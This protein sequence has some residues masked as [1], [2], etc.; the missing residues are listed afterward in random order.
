[1]SQTD[2]QLLAKFVAD[3][4]ESAFRQLVERNLDHSHSV[5]FRIARNAETARD[6]AQQVFTKLATN[7]SS[8]PKHIPFQSWLHT[9]T[10]SLAIDMVRSEQARSNREV[11]YADS[12]TMNTSE[13][14][15]WKQ[16]EPVLDEVIEQL[17]PADQQIIVLRFYR[18]LSHAE[19][20]IETGVTANAARVRLQRALE[21]MRILL[22]RKGIT[23]TAALLASALPGHA[24]TPA[25]AGMSMAIAQSALA[26][27]ATTATSTTTLSLL[28]MTKLQT[29]AI[30]TGIGLISLSIWQGSRIADL[31][32]TN[33][34]LIHQMDQNARMELKAE[35]PAA[36]TGDTLHDVKL[37]NKLV[38]AS[39]NLKSSLH[40]MLLLLKV[41]S[42]RPV[43]HPMPPGPGMRRRAES[44]DYR[45]AVRSIASALI[46]EV[47]SA[48]E[49]WDSVAAE[50]PSVQRDRLLAEIAKQDMPKL[51]HRGG[52]WQE[53]I[54]DRLTEI[55]K[56]SLGLRQ[57]QQVMALADALDHGHGGGIEAFA[58]SRANPD[59]IANLEAK[60]ASPET[61]EVERE[62]MKQWVEL[63]KLRGIDV[64]TW[65]EQLNAL[66][67]VVSRAPA[68][69][70]EYDE[71][72]RTLARMASH[73]DADVAISWIDAI[74]DEAIRRNAALEYVDNERRR[75]AR[76]AAAAAGQD[77]YSHPILKM[78]EE[79]SGTGR[80]M[81]EFLRE[82][83]EIEAMNHSGRRVITGQLSQQAVGSVSP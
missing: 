28:T 46:E 64:D 50:P 49:A 45:S 9:K 20:G 66:G 74:N 34:D 48:R 72:R 63:A 1:M 14:H 5:A 78:P 39:D 26:K 29:T 47:G 35:D 13:S 59:E 65:Y 23:T 31:K 77:H 57:A 51:G 42:G 19:I 12:T 24:I 43:D 79:L 8:L 58:R 38:P 62:G 17:K 21:R 7:P 75:E 73:E 76:E 60:I 6:V 36:Q 80:E 61:P 22:G 10:R 27:A 71:A 30:I 68:T 70:P 67:E 69:M 11:E 18:E 40:E 4:S 32:R 54:G 53:E 81:I 16:L 83:G 44:N 55:Q 37:A 25:P 15:H 2:R 33:A 56:S 52:E 41:I 82:H 3:G